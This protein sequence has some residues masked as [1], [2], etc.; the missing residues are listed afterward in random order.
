MDNNE[1]K[2]ITYN[3]LNKVKQKELIKEQV[4]EKN[5][6]RVES[7]RWDFGSENYDYNNQIKMIRDILKNNYNHNNDNVSKI[8]LQQIN[9]KIYGYKQQDI[10]KKLFNKTEFITLQSVV[11]KMVEC[12]LKCLKMKFS[13]MIVSQ[14]QVSSKSSSS[15]SLFPAMIWNDLC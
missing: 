10:I 4:K 3:A 15:V 14:I 9:K 11:N 6:K 7:E 12:E 13:R 2:S 5:K 8:A 1:I